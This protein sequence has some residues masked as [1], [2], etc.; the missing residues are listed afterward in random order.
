MQDQSPAPLCDLPPAVRHCM[1]RGARPRP[2]VQRARSPTVRADRS[3]VRIGDHRLRR[4]PM[5]PM[6]PANCD[7]VIQPSPRCD[8]G[9]PI[10]ERSAGRRPAASPTAFSFCPLS[11]CRT[12]R[13]R[14]CGVRR[15]FLYSDTGRG[16]RAE[17][18]LPPR[19]ARARPRGPCP[20]CLGFLTRRWVRTAPGVC[21]SARASVR[22]AC[23]T[24]EEEGLS[25]CPGSSDVFASYRR[26]DQAPAK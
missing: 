26:R 4:R 18:G 10:C 17:F 6:G 11:T 22:T 5:Q 19:A 2:R 3:K 8:I 7:R 1:G 12:I 24:R 15:A 9:K 23:R 20:A 16:S 25:F 13:S 14:P 21:L